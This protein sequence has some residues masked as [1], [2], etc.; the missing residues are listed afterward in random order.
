MVSDDDG[1]ALESER[2]ARDSSGE[3]DGEE[4]LLGRGLRVRSLEEKAD[5]VLAEEKR[6]R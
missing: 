4:N 3:I 6:E 5:V 1:A 2:L